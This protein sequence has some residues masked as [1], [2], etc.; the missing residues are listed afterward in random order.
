[1]NFDRRNF[2]R[3]GAAGLAAAGFGAL[4]LRADAAP[5]EPSGEAR[6]YREYLISV[7]EPEPG[8]LEIPP[9]VAPAK[10]AVTEDNILGPY[11]RPG[12]PFRGKIT[13][14]LEAGDVLVVRGRVW[15]FD[16][17][18]PLTTVILDV[19]Q[20][21]AEG[22][23]DN[24]DPNIPPKKNV[25]H[26]RARLRVDET[27]YYEYESIKPGKYQIAENQWRPPHV[28][29]MVGAPGYKTLVTQLY[30]SGEAENKVDAFIK[31]SLIIDLATVPTKRGNFKL[32]TFDIVLAKS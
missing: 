10:L 3:G 19:W 11:Y 30:F 15:A 14:P 13:P 31:P 29:Y 12:A 24:D 8:G 1:M 17:K 21:N 5:T 25:F 20:A 16:T 7:G 23:Y 2:L 26:N 4:T 9:P 18:K 6:T 28:H 32:G 27:G 22:R